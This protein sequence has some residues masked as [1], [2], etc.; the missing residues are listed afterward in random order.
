MG[1]QVDVSSTGSARVAAIRES[2]VL[3]RRFEAIVFDCDGTAVPVRR[4][5]ANRV[6]KLVEEASVRV[7]S[8]W[9]S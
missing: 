8:S 5:D 2:A 6:R 4:D 1:H 9:P 7:V 3:A